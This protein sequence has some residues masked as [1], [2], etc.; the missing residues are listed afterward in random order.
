MS[1]GENSYLIYEKS[2]DGVKVEW[3]VEEKKE[4]VKFLGIF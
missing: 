1:I 3:K 2:W 4:E